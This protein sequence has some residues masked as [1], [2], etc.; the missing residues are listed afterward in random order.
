VQ[1]SNSLWLCILREKG[2]LGHPDLPAE[3]VRSFFQWSGAFYKISFEQIL[4]IIIRWREN[5][6]IVVHADKTYVRSLEA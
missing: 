6:L 4:H 1:I 5:D 3:A 2:S